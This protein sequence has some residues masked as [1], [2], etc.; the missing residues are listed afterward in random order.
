MNTFDPEVLL[1]VRNLLVA[2][3]NAL[4]KGMVLAEAV[5]EGLEQG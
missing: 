5:L 3:A 2:T 4:E 1:D